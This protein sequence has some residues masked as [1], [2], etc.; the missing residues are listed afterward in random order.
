MVAILGLG[1]VPMSDSIAPPDWVT[2]GDAEQRTGVPRRTLYARVERKQLPS[3]LIDGTVHVRLGDV[4]AIAVQRA[5]CTAPSNAAENQPA[6]STQSA[7]PDELRQARTRVELRKMEADEMLAGETVR[8]T[9]D[10]IMAADAERAARRQRLALE[11]E[12]E[13]LELENA[14]RMAE[15]KWRRENAVLQ[16]E[17]RQRALESQAEEQRL[18]REAQARDEARH[19]REWV[20]AWMHEVTE[21]AL[22]SFGASAVPAAR[23]AASRVL[24]RLPSSMETKQVNDLIN[25]ELQVD[26]AEHIDAARRGEDIAKRAQFV[27]RAMLH[28][29]RHHTPTETDRIHRAAV[30]VASEGDPDERGFF[31]AVVRAVTEESTAIVAEHEQRARAEEVA[32]EWAGVYADLPGLVLKLMPAADAAMRE[33]ALAALK[34]FY[35]ER[36]PGMHVW[37][38]ASAAEDRLKL[39]GG[40]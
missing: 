30:R 6:A 40:E 36:P 20:A 14:R 17:A 2:I 37:Q 27:R 16:A 19:R 9:R 39:L 29:F 32:R 33:R 8:Q 3:R 10:E 11:T 28:V 21:W 1:S 23:A 15:L 31:R 35:D 38:F 12:R 7:M 34:S 24:E 18:R 26:L 4:Q 13:R 25:M 5:A 22:A